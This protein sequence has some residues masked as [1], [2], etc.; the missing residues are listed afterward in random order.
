MIVTL[1]GTPLGWVEPD[2]E[3]AFP[4]VP[5]GLFMVGGMR[6]LGGLAAPAR[7]VRLP[8]SIAMP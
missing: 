3:V 6:P 5:D 8:A 7:L 4:D 1:D 2:E